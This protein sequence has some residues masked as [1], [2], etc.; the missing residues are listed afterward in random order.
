MDAI[1]DRIAASMA[2]F[3]LEGWMIEVFLT[4][5]MTLLA[6]AFLKRFLGRLRR[7]FEKTTNPYDDAL[8]ASA[9]HMPAVASVAK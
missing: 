4:V 5:F 8:V 1:N 6:A 7:Q 9:E 2:R 3:G